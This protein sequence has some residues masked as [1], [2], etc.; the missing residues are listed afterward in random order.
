LDKI[1]APFY[2]QYAEN[3][4][5]GLVICEKVIANHEAACQVSSVAGEFSQFEIIFPLPKKSVKKQKMS[6]DKGSRSQS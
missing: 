4:G 3:A 2:T 5:L 6:V 1:W